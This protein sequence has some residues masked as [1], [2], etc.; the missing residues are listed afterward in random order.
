MWPPT[1]TPCECPAAGWCVRHQC[2]K[3]HPWHLLCRRQ[4][5]YYETWER[6]EGPGQKRSAPEPDSDVVAAP[7]EEIADEPTTPAGP[8]LL[9]RAWNFGNAVG[10]HLADGRRQVSDD[11]LEARLA[12]CRKC[13]SCD[14]AAM[15]CREPTCGCYLSIK[16][17]WQSEDC[18][19]KKWPTPAAPT[20]AE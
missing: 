1:V 12:V 7:S 10:R 3:P 9:Q 14:L 8:G 17:R 15:I 20:A 11:E 19:L 13:S 2:W 18:P 6:G 4:Q 16:A 5:V